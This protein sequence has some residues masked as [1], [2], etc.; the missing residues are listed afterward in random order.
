MGKTPIKH[1]FLLCFEN[2]KT[3]RKGI[4]YIKAGQLFDS[5]QS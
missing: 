5:K 4:L 2:W 1:I 3:T